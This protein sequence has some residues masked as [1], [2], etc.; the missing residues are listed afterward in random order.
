MERNTV[1]GIVLLGLLLTVYTIVNQ[2]SDEEIKAEQQKELAIQKKQAVAAKN[3]EI[4]K[5]NILPKTLAKDSTDTI[6]KPVVKKEEILKI[7]NAKLAIDLSTKG[8]QIE[9]VY[10]KEFNSYSTFASKLNGNKTAND[11]GLCLFNKGDQST[12]IQVMDGNKAIS[13]SSPLFEKSTVSSSKIIL[14]AK[15]PA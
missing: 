9:A 12:G 3:A 14:T 7:E 1:V 4:A 6:A 5:Q 15:T 13:T 8:G 10:L 2:P 11:R